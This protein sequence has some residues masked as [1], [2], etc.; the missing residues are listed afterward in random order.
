MIVAGAAVA[1]SLPVS[2]NQPSSTPHSNPITVVAGPETD[3]CRIKS[4]PRDQQ[5][6]CYS[7][8][9]CSDSYLKLNLRGGANVS[10]GE[11]GKVPGRIGYD[12]D[13]PS[14][15][16]IDFFKQAGMEIL[17]IPFRW[18]RVQ[19][20]LYGVLS[21]GDRASLKKA[22]DYATSQG[23]TVVLDMHD[24]AERHSSA[25]TTA[26]SRVG[27]GDLPESALV[28]AWTK[29][30]A[31]YRDNPKVWL[32]LMNE[33]NGIAAADW[34]RTVQ[35]VVVDLRGQHITNKLL[36]PGTSWTG[37]HSWISSGNSQYAAKLYDP[38][39][40]Y[41]FEVHQYLDSDSSGTHP[42]CSPGSNQRVDAVLDWAKHTQAKLFFGE[43][44]AGPT[45]SVKLSIPVCWRK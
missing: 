43:I 25:S 6:Y 20:S 45:P 36:V 7:A 14:A 16:E 2:S 30:G 24:Y 28:D 3:D 4:N 17:R 39:A 34:W 29:I 19:P 22:V 12:Y 18:E 27:S 9:S 42:T 21:V 35:Q 44:A 15:A 33:P 1:A 8:A 37:A 23:L 32:G 11:F 5:R 26:E 13:Y 38:L 40:N 41:A 31:D 10:G